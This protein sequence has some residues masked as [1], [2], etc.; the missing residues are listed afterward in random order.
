MMKE[1]RTN[2]TDQKKPQK[3]RRQESPGR[4][5]VGGAMVK[6]LAAVLG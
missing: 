1:T 6:S 2:G 5:G 3:V 4:R